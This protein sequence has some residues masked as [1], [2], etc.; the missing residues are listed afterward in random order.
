[1]NSS[2][3]CLIARAHSS[4]ELRTHVLVVMPVAVR[5]APLAMVVEYVLL[6][7]LEPTDI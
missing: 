3:V 7:K 1:M 5:M 4:K 2:M 6:L